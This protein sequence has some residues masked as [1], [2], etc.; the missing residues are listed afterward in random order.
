VV[1]VS[2]LH[3]VTAISTGELQACALQAGGTGSCWGWRGGLGPVEDAGDQLGPTL[4]PGLSGA[5]SVI[6]DPYHPCAVTARGVAECW[7]AS[8]PPA[9]VRGFAGVRAF[10]FSEDGQQTEHSCAVIA[11]GTVRCQSPNPYEGQ[12]G[13]GPRQTT[14][15]V[16]VSGLHGVTAISA[17]SF[18][19]CAVLAAGGVRCW[20]ANGGGQ[21]GDGTT[22]TRFRPVAVRGIDKPATGR[23]ALD[24]FAGTWVA[25]ELRL[26]I[27]ATGRARMVV[28]LGCC[29]HVINLSFRLSRVRGTYASARARARVT[30]VH[31]FAKDVFR[32]S[33]PP[34]VG[35]TGTLRLKRGIITEPFLGGMYCDDANAVRA[36][37][38]A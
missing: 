22:E 34:H 35:Q 32:G 5:V 9:V 11:G 1:T 6:G 29:T 4:V 14:R 7:G 2:G 17:G 28:Y 20:G 21:L 8:S 10:S 12:I 31:V 36:N 26:R 24:V 3:G 13:I 23:A 37:C 18:Y 16:T 33:R 25:H 19:T 30:G 15:V 38:G 27:T